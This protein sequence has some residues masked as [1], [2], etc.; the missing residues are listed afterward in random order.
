MKCQHEVFECA[1]DIQRLTATEG[2]PVTHYSAEIKIRCVQCETLFEFVGLPLG[3]SPYRPT[4]SMDGFEL[5]AP[6]TPM[7]VPVPEGL[8]SV[9]VRMSGVQQ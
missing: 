2:G 4:V 6:I 7:G 3:T 9:S 1:C 8:P 5:R